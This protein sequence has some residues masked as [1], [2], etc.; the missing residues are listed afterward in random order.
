MQPT[1]PWEARKLARIATKMHTQSLNNQ[2][3]FH[4]AVENAIAKQPEAN[5]ELSRNWLSN[6]QLVPAIQSTFRSRRSECKFDM[7]PSDDCVWY[8]HTSWREGIC[9]GIRSLRL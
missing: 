9:A 3:T 2:K 1:T 7:S 8:P 5:A 4:R 6:E